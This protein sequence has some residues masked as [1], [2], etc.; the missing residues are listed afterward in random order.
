MGFYNL[1]LSVNLYQFVITDWLGLAWQNSVWAAT[2]IYQLREMNNTA[3]SVYS[4][5]LFSFAL[6]TMM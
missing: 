5:P 2:A 1:N 4:T 6:C 3:F